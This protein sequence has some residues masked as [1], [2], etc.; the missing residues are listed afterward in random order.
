MLFSSCE[1]PITLRKGTP[2]ELVVSC[3]NCVPCQEQR[4]LALST[5]LQLEEQHSKY[6]YFITLT[7]DSEHIPYIDFSCDANVA[8]PCTPV[9][10][11]RDGS[12]VCDD[13]KTAYERTPLYDNSEPVLHLSTP[14]ETTYAHTRMSFVLPPLDASVVR[15]MLDIFNIRR[16]SYFD[17]LRSFA[18]V[19][20]ERCRHLK[21]YQ[22][23]VVPFLY[24]RDLQLFMKR[25]RKQINKNYNEKVRFYAIG[26]YGTDSLRPH[27]HILLFFNSSALSRA[28]RDTY[29]YPDSTQTKRIE[30]A[31]I[32]RPL[33][34]YGRITTAQT[35]GQCYGYVASYVTQSSDF[36]QI[37]AYFAP[38]KA[39]HS[40]FL[41]SQRTDEYNA[42]LLK[43]K[44][45]EE[46]TTGCVTDNKGNAKNVSLPYSCYSR[47]LPR[48]TGS[49]CINF[50]DAYTLIHAA[51]LCVD[52]VDIGVQIYAADLYKRYTKNH[53]L[54]RCEMRFISIPFARVLLD[55]C[56][57]NKTLNPLISLF[58]ASRRI[59]KLATASNL[60]M[61][62]YLRDIYF[63]FQS[64]LK[65]RVLK[66]L[67][68]T[69]E[70]N[71]ELVP[72]Y[73][74]A[75]D[76]LGYV[77]PTKYFVMPSY[78]SS[79]SEAYASHDSSI[80]HKQLSDYYKFKTY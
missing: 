74:G 73:Y 29:E 53:T 27:W 50:K 32:L 46:V 62:S 67:Y 14:K 63:P 34:K 42:A 37:L 3:N 61:Y 49:S 9:I 24:Y 65:L 25:L 79:V 44:R 48:F 51:N 58:Y 13:L 38:Q 57:D 10:G 59:Q 17:R 66:N 4:R 35:D 77:K 47:F 60:S 71:P 75:F 22:D 15:G 5:A 52:K 30:C 26:E 19:R 43:A 21:E 56:T 11:S 33:W 80:K 78:L 12:S 68:T 2:R 39:F 28:L 36:P 31:S 1:H 54:T 6:C 55:A 40:N 20:A 16:H 64:F 18:P 70:Q 76:G 69:L 7:Y 8:F 23:D 41:G 45:F 72:E